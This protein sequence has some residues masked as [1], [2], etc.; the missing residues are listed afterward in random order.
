MRVAGGTTGH[1]G[2]HA[3]S[4]DSQLILSV[5]A[6][7]H[8]LSTHRAS[9]IFTSRGSTRSPERLAGSASQCYVVGRTRFSGVPLLVMTPFRFRRLSAHPRFVYSAACSTDSEVDS[10]LSRRSLVSAA[11]TEAEHNQFRRFSEQAEREAR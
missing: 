10:R 9:N 11:Y 6:T 2:G 3:M 5:C 8:R 7:L 1:G 4:P